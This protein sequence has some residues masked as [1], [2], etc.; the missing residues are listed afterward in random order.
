VLP[1]LAFQ[2]T[3]RFVV[4]AV[5]IRLK[6]LSREIIAVGDRRECIAHPSIVFQSVIRCGG[7]RCYVAHNHPSGDPTP[8]P[9]DL[10][11]TANLIQAGK[12][13]QIPVLD[14]IVV[15]GDRWTSIREQ[16]NLWI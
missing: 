12:T 3:E 9:D 13:L 1:V 7:D 8:S 15:G 6:V 4:V 11:M 14:H 10:E 16:S 5:D 2:P